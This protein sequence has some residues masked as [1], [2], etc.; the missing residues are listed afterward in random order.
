MDPRIKQNVKYP[1]AISERTSPK[2]EKPSGRESD[3]TVSGDPRIMLTPQNPP[4][5]DAI[6]TIPPR[7]VVAGGGSPVNTELSMPPPSSTGVGIRKQAGYKFPE[8][9]AQ[10]MRSASAASNLTKSIGLSEQADNP[11]FQNPNRPE[12]N[13]R[14]QSVQTDISV[15]SNRAYEVTINPSVARRKTTQMGDT[16]R[17]NPKVIPPTYAESTQIALE[18]VPKFSGNIYR[19]VVVSPKG[20]L[21]IKTTD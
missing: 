8:K 10:K 16:G 4:D 20:P 5:D 18:I 15:P 1:Q 2:I 12:I 14:N 17:Q 6:S 13:Y 19:D 9:Q 3:S 11:E 7:K 21:N